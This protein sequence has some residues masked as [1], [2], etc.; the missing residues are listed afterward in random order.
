MIKFSHYRI[1]DD[2]R[3]ELITSGS[4]PQ[5]ELPFRSTHPQDNPRVLAEVKRRC[6]I[7]GVG[8]VMF[9]YPKHDMIELFPRD[10]NE[11]L[12]VTFK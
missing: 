6:G 9:H 11:V 7:I 12:S 1:A 5:F 8:C 4:L 10:R 3:L 2:N